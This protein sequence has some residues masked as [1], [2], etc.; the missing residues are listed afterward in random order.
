MTKD[1][2]IRYVAERFS[3]ELVKICHQAMVSAASA[4][5]SASSPWWLE[6]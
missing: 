2:L 6:Q 5:A 1:E 3:T 4:A